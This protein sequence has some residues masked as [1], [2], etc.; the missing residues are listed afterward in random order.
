VGSLLF[1]VFSSVGCSR[2]T[3]ILDSD[4]SWI[5]F[6]LISIFHYCDFMKLFSKSFFGGGQYWGLN[7]GPTFCATPTALFCEGFFQD[8]VSGTICL[9]WLQTEILLSS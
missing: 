1:S 2:D 9:D 6:T 5:I 4:W 7:S 3:F 8:K